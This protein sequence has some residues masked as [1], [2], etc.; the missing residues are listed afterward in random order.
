MTENMNCNIAVQHRYCVSC[1]DDI[2]FLFIPC[3]FTLPWAGFACERETVNKKISHTITSLEIQQHIALDQSNASYYDRIYL[4]MYLQEFQCQDLT[5]L[6]KYHV[7]DG[8][9]SCPN[10]EDEENCSH[11]CSFINNV[12][13]LQQDCYHAC[14]ASNCTCDALYFQCKSQGCIPS[15]KLCDHINDCNDRSDESDLLCVGYLPTQLDQHTSTMKRKYCDI[16]KI[17]QNYEYFH[18]IC[19]RKEQCHRGE[20]EGSYNCSKVTLIRG[21]R[22]PRDNIITHW[23]IMFGGLKCRISQDDYIIE[24]INKDL[25]PNCSTKGYAVKCKDLSMAMQ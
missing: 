3:D 13:A 15:S 24:F 25:G 4:E 17:G 19:D 20:D 14:H 12:H 10:G 21:F 22:C 1:D 5:F 18:E 23:V 6:L 9:R 7:C 16:T 11:V 2:L 8:I